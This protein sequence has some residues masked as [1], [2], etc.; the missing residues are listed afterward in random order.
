MES[1]Q[2]KPVL[3]IDNREIYA[4]VGPHGDLVCQVAR[5]DPSTLD[6]SAYAAVFV[7]DDNSAELN[8]ARE[9]AAKH[10]GG[11]YFKFTGRRG[12]ADNVTVHRGAYKLPRWVFQRY[13]TAFLAAYRERGLA[14]AVTA[15]IFEEA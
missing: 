14:D 11:V 4:P 12:Q 10:F 2:L 9:H 13:F 1:A 15:R 8:W 7:H 6:P 5:A 3:V